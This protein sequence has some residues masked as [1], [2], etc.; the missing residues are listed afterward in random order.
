M[1]I[2]EH[3]KW[4][5]RYP[6][7]QI[8]A[9]EDFKLHFKKNCGTLNNHV[10]WGY[11][12]DIWIVAS[13]FRG[14]FKDRSLSMTPFS[15]LNLYKIVAMLCHVWD[16]LFLGFCTSSVFTIHKTNKIQNKTNFTLMWPC[17][18][19]T[20]LFTIKPARCTN[21]TDLFWH[22]TLYISDSSSVH[23]QEFIHCAFSNGI[24]HEGL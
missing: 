8:H 12:I 20:H 2:S 19:V 17:G 3:M 10:F 23:H 22:E 18:I 21:F 5:Q 14:D 7:A 4:R 9:S 16:Y 13:G 11:V 1:C 6:S 24:C 15:S